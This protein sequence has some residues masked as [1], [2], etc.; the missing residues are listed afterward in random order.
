[1]KE[2]L[3][4]VSFSFAKA[5]HGEE[6]VSRMIWWW[7]ALGYL[8]AFFIANKLV[9]EINIRSVDIVISVMVML[10][11]A[12]HMYAIK[13]CAPKKPKLTP[14]EKKKL[15]TERRNNLGKSVARKLLLQE[16]LTKWD[17]VSIVMMIDLLCIT[18]FFSY[19]F[20]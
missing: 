11:F 5:T 13:K 8:I 9:R 2:F 12:W 18:H 20:R 17:P 4:K 1:M 3:D 16:P 14:E 19:I 6:S 15:K 7:G 10:Y